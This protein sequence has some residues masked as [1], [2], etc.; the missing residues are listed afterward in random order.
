[1][2]RRSHILGL[3]RVL[4]PG[5]VALCVA[6]Q[7]VT[8]QSLDISGTWVATLKPPFDDVEFVYDLQVVD[9]RITGFERLPFGEFRILESAA[10]GL[11]QLEPLPNTHRRSHSA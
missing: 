4:W 6:L 10:D 7:F 5:A 9:G 1:M 11:E 3:C 8:A 2:A